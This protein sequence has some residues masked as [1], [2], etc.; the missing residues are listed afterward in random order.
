MARSGHVASKREPLALRL[1][2]GD[3]PGAKCGWLSTSG[4]ESLN[5]NHARPMLAFWL[6]AILA[7]VITSVGVRAGGANV[8][9]RAGSPSQVSGTGSDLLLGGLL[10][11]Q[12]MAVNRLAPA[13]VGSA[14]AAEH[15]SGTMVDAPSTSRH[16][17]HAQTS[18]GGQLATVPTNAAGADKGHSATA[19]GRTRHQSGGSAKTTTTTTLTATTDTTRGNDHGPTDPGNGKGNGR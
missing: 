9:V 14:T 1:D 13:F 11:A 2:G 7:A 6:L 3:R 19:T 15:A 18:G 16:G 12:P 17:K 5:A 10:R 4:R 8:G